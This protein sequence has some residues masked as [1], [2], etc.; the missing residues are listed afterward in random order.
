MHSDIRSQ[1]FPLTEKELNRLPVGESDFE[2][3]SRNDAVYVDKTKLVYSLASSRNKYFLSRPRRFGKTLL[4]STFES[5]FKYGLRD[6]SGL[7][8]ETLWDDTTYD[9]MHLN[10]AD[11]RGFGNAE[12]FRSELCNWIRGFMLDRPIE[13]TAS[14]KAEADPLNRFA[15][16][17]SA[18]PAGK[19]VVLI[20]EYDTP[21]TRCLGNK[22]L[23]DAVSEI[24][25]QFYQILKN[26]GRALR[27]MFVTGIY[28]FQHLGLFSGPNQLIDISLKSKF[29]TLLGYTA[30]EVGKYFSDYIQNA[31][32]VLGI[33]HA[34][35]LEKLAYHYDGFCFDAGGQAH[36]YAPW[37]VL[38]FLFA[39]EDGFVNYWYESGG[40][41]TVLIKYLRNHEIQSP[42]NYGKDQVVALGRLQSSEDMTCLNDISMLYHTGYLTIKG[43]TPSG[44][45]RLNTPNNEVSISLASLYADNCMSSAQLDSFA[46]IALE[47]APENVVAA[48]N[49]FIESLDYKDFKLQDESSVRSMLQLCFMAVGFNPQIEVHNHK[50]RSDLEVRA[51]NRYFVFEI[52]YH[53][54]SSVKPETLLEEA[55]AQ[56]ADNHYGDHNCPGLVHIRIA[57]VFSAKE[58]RFTLSKIF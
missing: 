24:L 14:M 45:L 8:V 36:V 13:E 49:R 25:C 48:L 34:E 11:F 26:H 42:E 20:D 3:I 41:P 30:D 50:G 7:A 15:K 53:R 4:L 19:L 28:R 40:T 16:Y 31:A 12:D 57:M 5:L 1:S 52:K 58:R 51:G 43:V 47:A 21:L 18:A 39:P 56:I 17:L 10:F 6:F 32:N 22:P 33:S 46:R 9:V 27:F 54:D 35:C 2:L 23:F 55:V 37:S 44:N 29:S 38:N